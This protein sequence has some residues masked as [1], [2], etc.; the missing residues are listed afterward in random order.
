MLFLPV[1][2]KNKMPVRNGC[3]I[4]G[5]GREM[6]EWSGRDMGFV[7]GLLGRY[8]MFTV[9]VFATGGVM[10]CFFDE[11]EQKSEVYTMTLNM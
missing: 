6:I 10:G 4:V 8:V 7:M 5:T 1:C 2:G 9:A 3:F 11:E